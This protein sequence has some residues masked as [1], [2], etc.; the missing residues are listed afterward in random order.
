MMEDVLE[1][2]G[3]ATLM[4]RM[5]GHLKKIKQSHLNE[6]IASSEEYNERRRGGH[7]PPTKRSRSSSRVHFT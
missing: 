3:V 6:G 1:Y 7:Q 4:A 5:L 2:N